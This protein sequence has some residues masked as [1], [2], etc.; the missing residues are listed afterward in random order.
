MAIEVKGG[1][2]V[3]IRDLRSLKGV[4]DNDTALMAGLII[5][6]PLGAVKERNFRQFMAQA[7]DLIVGKS[8]IPKCRCSLSKRFWTESGLIR[9][10]QRGIQKTCNLRFQAASYDG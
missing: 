10:G 3:S 9:Q 7:G 5:M 6:E 4:L 8:R 2:N 1:K